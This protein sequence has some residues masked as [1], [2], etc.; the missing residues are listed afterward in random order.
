MF[1]NENTEIQEEHIPMQ[2]TC[3]KPV[4]PEIF[5]Q[6]VPVK[7]PTIT[8]VMDFSFD[9]LE[10][11]DST[12]EKLFVDTVHKIREDELVNGKIVNI[13]KDEIFV[14]REASNP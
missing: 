2:K 4:D 9:D 1:E 7:Q 8:S 11:D 5:A 3:I 13:T 12:F 10:M 6:S 14:D